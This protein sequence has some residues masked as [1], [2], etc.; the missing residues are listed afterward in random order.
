MQFYKSNTGFS[1]LSHE[2]EI[3]RKL[4]YYTETLTVLY[5]RAPHPVAQVTLQPPYQA[6]GRPPWHVM[7]GS[8]LDNPEPKASGR[9]LEAPDDV[10]RVGGE[11]LTWAGIP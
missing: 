5:A 11:G 4:Q 7:E 9:K 1:E 10:G 6:D 3:A 8:R 2:S